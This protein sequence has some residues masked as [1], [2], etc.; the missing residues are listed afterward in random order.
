VNLISGIDYRL[1]SGADKIGGI[2]GITVPTNGSCDPT[3]DRGRAWCGAGLLAS[4]ALAR[5]NPVSG[6]RAAADRP[7]ILKIEKAERNTFCFCN[8]VAGQ[9]NATTR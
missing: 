1:L 9:R 7:G 8:S 4:A 5:L 2:R 6:T 3:N